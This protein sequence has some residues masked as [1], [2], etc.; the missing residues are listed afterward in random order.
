MKNPL[1]N[2]FKYSWQYSF[3]TKGLFVLFIGLSIVA[4]IIGILEPLVVGRIFNSIQFSANDPQFLKY[5]I[6]NLLLLIV[7]PVGFWILHG[8]SRVLETKNAF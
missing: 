2:L 7:I 6:G 1:I 4:N 3:K 5:I 8:F